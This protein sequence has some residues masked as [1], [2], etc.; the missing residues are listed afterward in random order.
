MDPKTP[1]TDDEK[2]RKEATEAL[3]KIAAG[4]EAYDLKQ[5]QKALDEWR[6]LTKKKP[7]EK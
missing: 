1:T 7:E 3:S 2:K 6:E 4:V 5:Y